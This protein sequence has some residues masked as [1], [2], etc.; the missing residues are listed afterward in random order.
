M[1]AARKAG[2]SGRVPVVDGV[3]VNSF[4]DIG[5]SDG[6]AVWFHQQVGLEHRF[7]KFIE[8]W[9]EPYSF[10]TKQMRAMKCLWG[11]HYLPHDAKHERKQYR[12]DER[13]VGNECVRTGSSRWWPST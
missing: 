12:S 5:N 10:Y 3:E 8:G 7:F 13:R 2:R 9:G 4:W 1:T 11:T 6:T